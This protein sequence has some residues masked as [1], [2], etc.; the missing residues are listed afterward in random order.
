MSAFVPLICPACGSRL[1][2][3]E[4]PVRYACAS[5]GNEYLLDAGGSLQLPGPQASASPRMPPLTAEVRARLK[6]EAQARW[7][8]QQAEFRQQQPVAFWLQHQRWVG[9]V[10][11]VVAAL[12]IAAVY[13]LILTR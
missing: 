7:D 11:F 10:V 4:D 1:A 2:A 9:I 8:R 12:L 5:C 6:A 3:T 13:V